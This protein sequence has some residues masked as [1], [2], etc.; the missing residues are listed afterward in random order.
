VVHWLSAGRS[1]SRLARGAFFSSANIE[2]R[3]RGAVLATSSG[4]RLSGIADLGS[5]VWA[6]LF[7]AAAAATDGTWMRTRRSELIHNAHGM[8]LEVGAGT[9][10]NLRHYHD[11]VRLVL[12]EPSPG[13]RGRLTR[14]LSRNG[15]NAEVVEGS[16]AGLP[17]PD[18]SFNTVVATLVLCSVSDQAQALSEIRRVLRP[19]GRLLLIEHVR[20]AGSAAQ[21]QDRLDRLWPHV[22]G[23]CHLN[24]DTASALTRAGFRPEREERVEPLRWLPVVGPH[25][26]GIYAT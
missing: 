3:G 11:G 25:I 6:A 24:R 10:L 21:W 9:G 20:G 13:M 4:G 2:A 17:F 19:H 18:E 5:H 16:L 22:A 1:V 15:G 23:G 26:G 8:T 12:L 14:R 7:D